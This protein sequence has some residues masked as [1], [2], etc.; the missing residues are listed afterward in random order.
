MRFNSNLRRNTTTSGLGKQ[1]KEIQDTLEKSLTQRDGQWYVKF[2]IK[3]TQSASENEGFAVPIPV[4]SESIV[5]EGFIELSGLTLPAR[6]SSL[7]RYRTQDW[8]IGG[9]VRLRGYRIFDAKRGWSDVRLVLA[10]ALEWEGLVKSGELTLKSKNDSLAE[11][12]DGGITAFVASIFNVPADQVLCKKPS[13]ME[14]PILKAG[15]NR[16]KP[17]IELPKNSRPTLD[18]YYQPTQDVGS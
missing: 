11:T 13:A 10:T 7:P 14:I 16:A 4:R 2:T 18:P 17:V 5:R 15:I 1:G 9:T 12:S 8:W 3:P 6:V